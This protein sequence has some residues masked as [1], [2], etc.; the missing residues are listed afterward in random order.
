MSTATTSQAV[1]EKNRVTRIIIGIVL[2]ALSGVMLLLSFPPYGVWPL[3][4]VAFV[5]YLFAQY[6][7][8]PRKWSSLAPAIALLIWLGCAALSLR[9]AWRC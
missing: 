3:V 4:W 7:L 9:R 2:S 1:M 6:R 5:P 8:W